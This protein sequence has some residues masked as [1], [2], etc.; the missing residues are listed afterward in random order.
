[1][2]KPWFTLS[3]SYAF[4]STSN[5]AVWINKDHFLH[6]GSPGRGGVGRGGGLHPKEARLNLLEKAFSLPASL[7]T[8]RNSTQSWDLSSSCPAC[9]EG[10]D[11]GPLFPTPLSPLRCLSTQEARNRSICQRSCCFSPGKT[12]TGSPITD[13]VLLL[14]RG[15]LTLRHP[16]SKADMQP[17]T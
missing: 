3:S 13:R 15:L 10:T 8:K 9:R 4:P 7:G 12:W 6:Q 17:H 1:V 5:K 2:F 11:H 16:S 14:F